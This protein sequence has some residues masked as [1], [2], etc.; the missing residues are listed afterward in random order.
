MT[1][2]HVFDDHGVLDELVGCVTFGGA[3]KKWWVVLPHALT[4][5]HLQA[6]C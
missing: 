3:W 2:F 5:V 6:I 1:T 4:L